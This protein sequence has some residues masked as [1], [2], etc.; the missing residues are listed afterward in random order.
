MPVLACLNQKGGVGKTTLCTNLATA[1]AV[2]GKKVL[3]IDAPAAR[4]RSILIRS[5]WLQ[6][7]Q[8][9]FVNPFS[10]PL[11]PHYHIS[12]KVWFCVAV[13]GLL[14]HAE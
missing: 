12:K 7:W 3:L 6:P 11:R 5:R 10:A 4:R 9:R 8:A 14:S 2:S 13:P 1:L